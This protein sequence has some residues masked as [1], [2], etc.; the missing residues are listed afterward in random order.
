MIEDKS[1]SLRK[2]I[3]SNYR[4]STDNNIIFNTNIESIS[5]DYNSIHYN[6]ILFNTNT[7]SINNFYNYNHYFCTNCKKFPFI[8]FCKDRK[9]IRFICSCFNNKKISIKE[10]FKRFSIKD[11]L[12]IFFFKANLNI[13][14]ED[15]LICKEHNKKFKGFSKFYLNNYCEK[16]NEY[17]YE[18]YDN[19]IIN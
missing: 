13:N 3:D 16:C 17:K 5:N 9:N 7:E 15:K 19:D 14:I 6:S 2:L 10:F 12:L 4:Q 18:I 1:F 11:N 8:K